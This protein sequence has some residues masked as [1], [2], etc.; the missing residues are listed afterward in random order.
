MARTPRTKLRIQKECI[1]TFK[2]YFQVVFFLIRVVVVVG[3]GGGDVIYT[4]RHTKLE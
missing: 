4:I 1:I 3:G 2:A